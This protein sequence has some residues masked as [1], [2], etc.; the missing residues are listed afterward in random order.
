MKE[1][2]G[3]VLKLFASLVDPGELFAGTAFSADGDV[4]RVD[5]DE[6]CVL[7]ARVEQLIGGPDALRVAGRSI[8]GSPVVGG[9]TRILA[10]LASPTTL[11][12]ASNRWGGPSLFANVQ[13]A[14]RVVGRN[15][16]ELELRIP[17]AYR[18][19]PQLFAMNAGVFESLPALLGLPHSIVTIDVMPR[20]CTYWIVLPPSLTLWS[21]LRRAMMALFSTR[22]VIEELATQQLEL[23]ER[24]L[25]LEAAH[26]QAQ[27]QQRTA[28]LARDVAEDALKAKAE[29]L[30]TVG[31]E[32]RTPLNGILGMCEVLRGT[33]LT[34]VQR[35]CADSM[36]VSGAA[37]LGMVED[38]LRF[39]QIEAGRTEKGAERFVMDAL[40]EGLVDEFRE[41][42]RQARVELCVAIDAAV[43]TAVDGQPTAIRHVL[44]QLVGNAVKFTHEGEVS[45]SVALDRAD[46]DVCWVRW[47]VRD[48]GIG[49]EP[50]LLPRLFEPFHQGDGSATRRYGGLGLGLAL[51][52]GLVGQLGGTLTVQSEVG[53]GS[54]F[55]VL[56]PLRRSEDG[57]TA[58]LLPAPL[59]ERGLSVLVVDDNRTTRLNLL[60]AIERLGLQ[61]WGEDGGD[62]AIAAVGA[63]RAVDLVLMDVEMPGMDGVTAAARLR[64][65]PGHAALPVVLL[66]AAARTVDVL[67]AHV[68]GV[69]SKP[70]R[71]ADLASCIGHLGVGMD[72]P[73]EPL[74]PSG[75]ADLD[76]SDPAARQ[77]LVVEDNPINQRVLQFTL[78]G[79]GLGV[80]L[81][82]NGAVAVDLVRERGADFAL[83]LMDCHMPV[84]DGLD[85]TRAIR[86]MGG[87]GLQVPIVAV[88]ADAQ[89]GTRE[90]CIAA[91]MSD[92]MTKPI[93]RARM[94][95]VLEKWLPTLVPK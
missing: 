86:A 17:D 41:P 87:V 29:F 84:L 32:L 24:Y 7:I 55:T 44:R 95:A 43:P 26:R 42:A 74:A 31:H 92:Y 82:D 65:L 76:P 40:V 57:A 20:R 34:A 91:G 71:F 38:V 83:V 90:R 5:W 66:C 21:R 46:G 69:L 36:K 27:E 77:V 75:L 67:P 80:E 50:A 2:S 12:W 45:V 28:E 54:S 19:C 30:T 53:T 85:A 72:N 1:V 47:V 60:A 15:R 37:L 70:V 73:T 94:S 10:L 9:Q 23:K 56:L 39:S 59:V 93:S 35:E 14:M 16:L 48:T 78:E 58:A 62:A 52:R 49:I 64:A 4:D 13:N 79:L 68:L 3:K 88:T 61:A 51:C 22:M 8:A 6:F 25:S 81:A 89:A 63:G 18:D 33:S 11:Y